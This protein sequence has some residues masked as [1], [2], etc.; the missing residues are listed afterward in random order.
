MVAAVLFPS[1]F[2]RYEL[3]ALDDGGPPDIGKKPR[4]I[5]TTDLRGTIATVDRIRVAVASHPDDLSR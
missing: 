5:P 3:R 1:G 2:A 4:F